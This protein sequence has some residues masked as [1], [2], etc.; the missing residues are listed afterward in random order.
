MHALPLLLA[1][2]LLAAACYADEPAPS[3]P[4]TQQTVGLDATITIHT[5]DNCTAQITLTNNT[6]KPLPIGHFD[7]YSVVG[8]DTD[9]PT[10]ISESPQNAMHPMVRQLLQPGDSKTANMTLSDKPLP[11]GHYKF[12]IAYPVSVHPNPLAS[13]F[14]IP[15][16]TTRPKRK[17]HLV[18]P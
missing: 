10:T 15:S 5:A 12:T 3:P 8:S 2:L 14:D 6:D 1:A 18:L 17:K 4:T 11:P 13:E 16:A 9:P 7:S